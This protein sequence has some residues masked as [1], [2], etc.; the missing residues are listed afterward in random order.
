MK[1]NTESQDALSNTIEQIKSEKMQLRLNPKVR[2]KA[3]KPDEFTQ[4]E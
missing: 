3:S 2:K 1:R 4:G